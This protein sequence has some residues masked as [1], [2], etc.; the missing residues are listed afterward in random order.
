MIGHKTDAQIKYDGRVSIS[1][2]ILS[3]CILSA[4]VLTREEWLYNIFAFTTVFMNVMLLAALCLT[5]A[6][7]WHH[8]RVICDA[9]REK[10]AEDSLIALYGVTQ[11]MH[12]VYTTQRV[13]TFLSRIITLTSIVILVIFGKF[14]VATVLSVGLTIGLFLAYASRNFEPDPYIEKLIAEKNEK[15][16]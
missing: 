11:K 10:D 3:L 6:I 9:S 8:Y 16:I 14:I 4:Y 5:G 7:L 12:K 15:S 2:N 13:Q 1:L